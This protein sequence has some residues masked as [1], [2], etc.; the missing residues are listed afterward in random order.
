[1]LEQV[2]AGR[3]VA[4]NIYGSDLKQKPGGPY[5]RYHCS[6]IYALCVLHVQ[7]EQPQ[8]HCLACLTPSTSESFWQIE[9]HCRKSLPRLTSL[10]PIAKE[11]FT[12]LKK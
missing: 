8:E 12:P 11:N 9:K 4:F 5:R 2:L 1:M 3:R 7:G 10:Q 6:A